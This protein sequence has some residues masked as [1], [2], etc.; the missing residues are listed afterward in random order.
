M[1]LRVLQGLDSEKVMMFVDD[2]YQGGEK[3]E[4]GGGGGMGGV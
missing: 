3:G 4:G 1:K 2:N